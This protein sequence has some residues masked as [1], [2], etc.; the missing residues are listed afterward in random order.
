MYLWLLSCLFLCTE[1]CFYVDSVFII[2]ISSVYSS[3]CSPFVLPPYLPP[4]SLQH[5]ALS[6]TSTN[7]PS[8]SKEDALFDQI[9]TSSA[10]KSGSGLED[11]AGLQGFSSP[12]SAPS[13][14]P[15]QSDSFSGSNSVWTQSAPS[16]EPVHLRNSPIYCGQDFV[17]R[18]V[19][20]P[21][22]V[23]LSLSCKK[24]HPLR[25]LFT[26]LG[27]VLHT[28]PLFSPTPLRNPPPPL[29]NPPFFPTAIINT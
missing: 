3:I 18:G 28:I 5:H 23:L 8:K 24:T 27:Q 21:K 11:L 16:G 12:P 14:N 26:P 7:E 20:P 17:E 22:F 29:P 9:A 15:F 10:S 25:I 6:P 1:S 13:T 19:P 2:T 4:L